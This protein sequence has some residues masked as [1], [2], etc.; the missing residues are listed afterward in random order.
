MR[1]DLARCPAAI[2][3]NPPFAGFG[4]IPAQAPTRPATRGAW[5]LGSISA[6]AAVGRASPC[7][8]G[9]IRPSRSSRQAAFALQCQAPT[10]SPGL[11]ASGGRFRAANRGVPSCGARLQ[12][13]CNFCKNQDHQHET[14]G[15][16]HVWGNA[17]RYARENGDRH[18][19]DN[20]DQVRQRV[21]ERPETGFRDSV[22]PSVIRQCHG[23]DPSLSCSPAEITMTLGPVDPKSWNV[24]VQGARA[25]M[26]AAD[27][28]LFR[29][30]LPRRE[31]CNM[32]PE[33]QL[34]TGL[35]PLPLGGRT[36]VL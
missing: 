22:V 23:R 7:G 26:P 34:A 25:E 27:R 8:G 14:D 17:C 12:S 24:I 31:C 3:D 15:R 13:R 16:E 20:A 5:R 6:A 9:D 30:R 21:G 33:T 32:Y 2:G 11:P 4:Q 18:G 28:T 35:G 36:K 10:V 29:S 1:A 19:D